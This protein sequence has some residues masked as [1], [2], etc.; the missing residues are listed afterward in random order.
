[1]EELSQPTIEDLEPEVRSDYQ[2]IIHLGD[3]RDVFDF[4][5]HSFELKTLTI[6]EELAAGQLLRGYKESPLAE[7]AAVTMFMAA[8]IVT[9]DGKP[10]SMSLEATSSPEKEIRARFDVIRKWRPPVIE[11][12]NRHFLELQERMYKVFEDLQDL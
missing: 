9:V 11:E 3:I 1:M 4:A 7:K 12:L 6:E 2:D 8:S 10:L 5:G